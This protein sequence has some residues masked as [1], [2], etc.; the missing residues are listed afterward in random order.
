MTSDVDAVGVRP[1]S[2]E[3]FEEFRSSTA[4]T[5]FAIGKIEDATPLQGYRRK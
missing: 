3:H 4:Y 2:A 1:L 5:D